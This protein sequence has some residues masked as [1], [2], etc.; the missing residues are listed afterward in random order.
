MEK[1]IPGPSTLGNTLVG[2]P[3]A[4]PQD[5]LVLIPY[6][7][8]LSSFSG[9]IVKIK[10]FKHLYL[11]LFLASAKFKFIQKN[12]KFICGKRDVLHPLLIVYAAV[13]VADILKA[14]CPCPAHEF[15]ETC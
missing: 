3:L 15:Y 9:E 5:S 8:K 6:S 1:V 4:L 13:N 7:K 10:T 2:L 11:K 12:R 14:C